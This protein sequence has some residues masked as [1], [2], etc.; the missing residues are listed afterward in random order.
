[1]GTEGLDLETQVRVLC[2]KGQRW[3]RLDQ[4]SEEVCMRY[5]WAGCEKENVT[6]KTRR[7]KVSLKVYG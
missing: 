2:P 6:R 7:Y 3:S 4:I 1:M 5:E